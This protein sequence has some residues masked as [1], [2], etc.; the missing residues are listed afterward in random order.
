MQAGEFEAV[1]FALHL[2]I[3]ACLWLISAPWYGHTVGAWM[4]RLMGIAAKQRK[5]RA[6]LSEP[7][8]TEA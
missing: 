5:G 3:A 2:D 6:P 1:L 8:A 4:S 7:Q